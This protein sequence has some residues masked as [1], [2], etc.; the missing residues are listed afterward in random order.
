MSKLIVGSYLS[1]ED[2]VKAINIYELTGHEAKNIIALTNEENKESL[3]DLTDV[4]V[5]SNSPKD[6]E[7][8][9]MTDKIKNIFTDNADLELDTL[10]KL[11][12]YGLSKDDA[13]RCMTDVNLGK[14]VILADDE[15]RMG[16]APPI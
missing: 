10:D 6:D 12:E 11:I 14:I 3:K 9:R 15:L 2:A 13:I 8:L 16:Q 5:K 1:Q 4:A 7:N